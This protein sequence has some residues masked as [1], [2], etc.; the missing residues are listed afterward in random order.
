MEPLTNDNTDN[1]IAFYDNYRPSLKSGGYTITANQSIEGL[2]TG[3][4]LQEKTQKFVVD[5][6]Q[7]FLESKEI[8]SVYPPK[9]S[10]GNFGNIL[11]HVVLN[12]R[13]LPWERNV[14]NNTSEPWIALL[15]FKENE[16][17]ENKEDYNIT[18]SVRDFLSEKTDT[19][20]PNISPSNLPDETLNSNCQ[21]IL[22]QSNLFKAVVPN[23]DEL[24]Y[25]AHVREVNIEN[26]E[27]IGYED[28]GWFS[29]ITANRFPRMEKVQDENDSITPI[30]YLAYLVSLEGLDEYLNKDSTFTKPKIQL[31]SLLNWSF[32]SVSGSGKTFVE[33]M[34]GF[35]SKQ[36]KN[37]QNSLLRFP[38]P[39]D[40]SLSIDEEVKDRIYNSFLPLSYHTLFGEETFAWYRSPFVAT[41][42]QQLPIST[43]NDSS[44]VTIYV[45]KQGVF[46][47]SYTNAW[48]IGRAMALADQDFSTELMR[49]RRNTRAKVNQ[50][51]RLYS[52]EI[53]TYDLDDLKLDVLNKNNYTLA[54]EAMRRDLVP[55][56]KAAF[57]DFNQ[58][59]NTEISTS[60]YHSESIKKNK[61]TS[62]KQQH[63]RVFLKGHKVNNLLNRNAETESNAITDWLA[64]KQLLYG[65]PFI[66]LVPD[67]DM[68]PTESIRFFYLDNNWTQNLISGALSIGVQG[69]K[70]AAIES[71]TRETIANKVRQ[72]A[73]L[74]RKKKLGKPIDNQDQ[75]FNEKTAKFS[76]ILIRSALVAGWPGLEIV[77]LKNGEK[78]E[79][80]RMD[81][82][83]ENVLLCLFNTVPDTLQ[84][85]EPQQGLGFGTSD[86]GKI[87]LRR[88]TPPVGKLKGEK[89]PSEN[90]F[91]QFF[92]VTKNDIG[93]NVID[94]NNGENSLI[95]QLK[96]ALAVSSMG[97]A[98]FAIQMVKAPERLDFTPN[99]KIV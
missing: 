98:N 6:P 75:Q 69:S 57:S 53:L 23:M 17:P 71:I 95:P 76:G 81:R 43:T 29:V 51:Y 90:N 67:T 12:R 54:F 65:V 83:S 41:T 59:K 21:S 48:Q 94:L 15:I 4:N 49:Y 38:L 18:S 7:F 64:K 10:E 1:K 47:L 39:D 73:Q 11:P 27:I 2:D 32:S 60:P 78:A 77:P 42:P 9:N 28:S 8:Y 13:A 74:I 37:P 79:I 86:E 72:T 34:N 68:L 52:S 45:Q 26:Q 87:E 82:L 5:G 56:F 14:K 84:L 33:L 70:D 92:R 22:L 19:I 46:D 66:H 31:I 80:I 16:L 62:S 44:A 89:F 85:S 96:K 93:K 63:L 20:K 91:D 88:L 58:I 36:D 25:L 61:V 30:N 35:V 40:L 3:N 50:L 55:T 97:A 24:A 99:T